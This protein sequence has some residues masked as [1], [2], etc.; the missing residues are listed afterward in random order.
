MYSM[1]QLTLPICQKTYTLSI[2]AINS[3]TGSANLNALPDSL[4]N[5]EFDNNQFSGKIDLLHLP[6]K[7]LSLTFSENLFTGH[8]HIEGVSARS[9]KIHADG[10]Q[11]SGVATVSDGLIIRLKETNI[12]A[13]INPKGGKSCFGRR[14]AQCVTG[15]KPFR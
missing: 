1:E 11:F 10:N 14:Y 12:T 7:L 5:L 9:I 13:V 6:A 2:F 8:F 15:R 4:R 3:F